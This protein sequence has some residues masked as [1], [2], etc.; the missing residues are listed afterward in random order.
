MSAFTT[1]IDFLRRRKHAYVL[2]F[3]S[4]PGQRVLADLIRFCR[5]IETTYHDDARMSA[6]LE[7]RKEVWMRI[8]QHLNLQ[9]EQLFVI[10]NQ[11]SV[12]DR[13]NL[14]EETDNG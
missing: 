12:L 3:A 11:P 13:L 1:T 9:P 10:F 8:Q 6:R 2:A 5:G 7:G 4:E 14:K